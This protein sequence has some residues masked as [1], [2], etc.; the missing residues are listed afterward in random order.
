MRLLANMAQTARMGVKDLEDMPAPAA[1]EAKN[2]AVDRLLHFAAGKAETA[3]VAGVFL[4]VKF[5]HR[6]SP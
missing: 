3:Q 4:W 2:P 1:T 6:F 5:F